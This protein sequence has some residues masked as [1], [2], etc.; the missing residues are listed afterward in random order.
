MSM[1]CQQ[2]VRIIVQNKQIII[3]FCAK[4][5]AS[6]LNLTGITCCF[7]GCDYEKYLTFIIA[8]ALAGIILCLVRQP[9]TDSTDTS[10]AADGLCQP[11]KQPDDLQDKLAEKLVRKG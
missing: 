8:G 2:I 1:I 5:H 10:Y 6:G 11:G 9:L 3:K 7:R 4:S